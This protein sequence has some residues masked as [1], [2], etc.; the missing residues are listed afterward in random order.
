MN[1]PL[2]DY[3]RAEGQ[4]NYADI[5]DYFTELNQCSDEQKAKYLADIVWFITNTENLD[6]EE[7]EEV[8]ARQGVI[9][10]ND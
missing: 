3:I 10:W 4:C 6:D 7:F 8:F 9:L 1:R 2:M 5:I